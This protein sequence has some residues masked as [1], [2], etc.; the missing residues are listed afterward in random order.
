MKIGAGG[1]TCVRPCRSAFG[2]R[3]AAPQAGGGRNGE[4]TRLDRSLAG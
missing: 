1:C 4:V 2:Y 3:D